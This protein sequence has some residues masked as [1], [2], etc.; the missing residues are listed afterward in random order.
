MSGKSVTVGQKKRAF[1][2]FL[3]INQRGVDLDIA[4]ISHW[5]YQSGEFLAE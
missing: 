2:L 1:I 4:D 3:P 5:K